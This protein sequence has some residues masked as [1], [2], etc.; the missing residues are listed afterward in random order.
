MSAEFVVLLVAYGSSQ[1][2]KFF[3]N[4]L[5]SYFLRKVLPI[6]DLSTYDVH[7]LSRVVFLQMILYCIITYLR[8]ILKVSD[9][10]W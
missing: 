3:S 8:M 4:K 5:S 7:S 2:N 1:H 10:T 6:I 9:F